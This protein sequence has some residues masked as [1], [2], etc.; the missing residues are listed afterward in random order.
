MKRPAL[1]AGQFAYTPRADLHGVDERDWL[2]ATLYFPN[3]ERLRRSF[4][5]VQAALGLLNE[6]PAEGPAENKGA[7]RIQITRALLQNLID[8]P[9]LAS[10]RQATVE[11]VKQ[12]SVAGDCLV[13][14]YITA[15]FP[16]KLGEPSLRKA[17]HVARWF[18]GQSH[19][20]D[21]SKMS[22]RDATIR[23][24]WNECRP[25]AHLWGAFRLLRTFPRTFARD[26]FRK[27]LT[28][29]EGIRELYGVALTLA[30]FGCEFIP[31]RA[32]PAEPLLDATCLYKIPGGIAPLSR[33]L[34][35]P[36][37]SLVAALRSYKT[38]RSAN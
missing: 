25:A 35:Q 13:T 3:D 15:M 26:E 11:G 23:R 19:Y 38:P 33:N 6:A 34:K 37:E 2:L 4:T 10:L 29:P 14:V 9:D 27:G 36:P 32:R 5:V 24:Y 16:E 28:T 7:E 1:R 21:G 22:T 20:G 31:K 12:G 30:N 8:A 17:F 18:A